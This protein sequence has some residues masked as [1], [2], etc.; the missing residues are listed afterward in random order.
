MIAMIPYLFGFQ[1]VESLVV[2]ALEGP[3]KRFGPLL[4]IDLGGDPDVADP[5][6][7]E[8]QAEQVV[9]ITVKHA[10]RRVLVVAFSRGRRRAD[11]VVQRVLNGLAAAGVAVEDAFRA[12][13][14]RWWSYLC[15]NPLCCS[16]DGAV[17]DVGTSRV[18]AE[19]VVSGLSFEP[20]RDALRALLTPAR[21]QRSRRGPGGGGA[22]PR[23]WTARAFAGR[24]S[25]TPPGTGVGKAS[26]T[27][28]DSLRP[29]SPGSRSPFSQTSR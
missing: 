27:H 10:L 16:P 22:P 18:A 8:L 11:P 3:R 15:R 28:R 20:D 12:D 2:V 17:Y 4:R 25:A 23:R 19:A 26:T 7:A 21:G 9:A 29:T 24:R 6:L 5:V 1:P 14:T 13:G